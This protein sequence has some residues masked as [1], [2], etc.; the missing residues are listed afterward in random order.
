MNFKLITL[1]CVIA[2]TSCGMKVK[3]LDSLENI[4]IKAP[5]DF[6]L[7]ADFKKVAEFCDDRYG[8]KTLEAEACFKDYRDFYK[9]E[10]SFDVTAFEDYCSQSYAGDDID[11]CIDDLLS[12]FNS[13]LIQQ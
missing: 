11:S 5:E 1:T 13:S 2:L 6:T 8:K 10:I 9:L 4:N 3:G 12:I 7:G